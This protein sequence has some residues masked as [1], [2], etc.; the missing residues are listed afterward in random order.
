M[1]SPE[2]WCDSTV[3]GRFDQLLL[4]LQ[5]SWAT[6]GLPVRSVQLDDWWYTSEITSHDHMCVKEWAPAP[7]L[8]PDGLPKLAPQISYNLY[9]P[10]WCE[11]NV[12]RQRGFDFLNSSDPKTSNHQ[13]DPAPAAAEAFYTELFREQ[14]AAGVTITNYEVQFCRGCCC[15]CCQRRR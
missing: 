13:S 12:Y 10:F 6:A 4:N 15:C 7:E 2:G 11:D 9:G 5:T 8:F 1:Y 14:K 3:H